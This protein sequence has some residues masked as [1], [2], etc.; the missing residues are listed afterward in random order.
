M[1]AFGT[2]ESVGIAPYS[3]DVASMPAQMI[4]VS[5]TNYDLI[6]LILAVI[7]AKEKTF[8]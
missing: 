2:G 3:H 6:K 1:Q 4:S 5:M 7:L 8:V